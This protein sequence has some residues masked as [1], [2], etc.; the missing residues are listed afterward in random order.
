MSR[1]KVIKQEEA[2][3]RLKDIYDDLIA[4]RGKL[5]EVHMI[6]SL[7]PESIVKHM[8]L[9]MEI[10]FTKSE[11][12]RAE[13]EMVAVVVSASNN[14]EYCQ[15]H[16]GEALNQYWKDEQKVKLLRKDFRKMEL[17]DR[18]FRLCAFAQTL[19][20]DPKASNDTD[21]TEPLRNA[22]LNDN[23]ILDA[24]LVIA[25]FNFVNRIVMGLNVNVEK[26]L[27]QGYKY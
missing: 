19:T 25:Y 21:A 17:S 20:L 9:Y 10:M 12:S 3:G 7:R 23:A 11:L 14:C 5:A 24:T 6:Q 4:K 15:I 18:S 26:D 8:E 2:T 1:I 16:H 13:R 27:G 22:G